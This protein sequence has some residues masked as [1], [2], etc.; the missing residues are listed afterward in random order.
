MSKAKINF[1]PLTASTPSPNS[2][3]C[4]TCKSDVTRRW[5]PSPSGRKFKCYS[6]G[7]ERVWESWAEDGEGDDPEFIGGEERK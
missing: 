4:P 5:S 3:L 6:C 7:H 1:G 2:D